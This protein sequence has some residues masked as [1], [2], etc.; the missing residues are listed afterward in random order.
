MEQS[1]QN[2]FDGLINDLESSLKVIKI[3]FLFDEMSRMFI[4]CMVY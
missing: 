4:N 1:N 3:N 2:P